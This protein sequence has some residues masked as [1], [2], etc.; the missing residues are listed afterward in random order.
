MKPE[1]VLKKIMPLL[2]EEQAEK[3]NQLTCKGYIFNSL[4]KDGSVELISPQPEN[5]PVYVERNGSAKKYAGSVQA[6]FT[7]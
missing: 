1:T 4:F 5:S 6:G 2:A 7:P 3:I